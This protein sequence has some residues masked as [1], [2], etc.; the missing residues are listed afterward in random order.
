MTDYEMRKLAK[1]QAEFLAE[2]LKEDSE[3]LDLMFPPRCMN[4]EEASEY[5]RIPVGTIYQ[6][7]NEIPHEKVGKRL[8]FTDRGLMRWMKRKTGMME[9]PIEVPIKK[10]M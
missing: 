7:I 8:V 2:K 4:I 5:T 1:L 9:V 6:K 3:L 10:V